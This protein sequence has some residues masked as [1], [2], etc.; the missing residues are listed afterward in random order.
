M[1]TG[2]QMQ[3]VDICAICLEYEGTEKIKCGHEFH[4]QC[5]EKWLSIKNSCPICRQPDDREAPPADPHAVRVHIVAEPVQRNSNRC[6]SCR[7]IDVVCAIP[8]PF[9]I[10]PSL[11]FI[12]FFC[13]LVFTF[14]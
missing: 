7:F 4:D 8:L 10:W 1:S 14:S 13:I 2:Y 6:C 12:C 5:I 11:I 9:A 3:S